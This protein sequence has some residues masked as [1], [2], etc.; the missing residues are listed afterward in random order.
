MIQ[1]LPIHPFLLQEYYEHVRAFRMIVYLK[2]HLD[3]I[4][5]K[6]E[7]IKFEKKNPSGECSLKC[8]LNPLSLDKPIC[9]N[10]HLESQKHK[11]ENLITE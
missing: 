11:R 1:D 6:F 4:K 8:L 5:N 10:I 7:A 2:T 9:P 3:L